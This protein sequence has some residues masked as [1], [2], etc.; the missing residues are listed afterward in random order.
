V[1]VLTL[2]SNVHP[3]SVCGR[4]ERPE[5]THDF[6]QEIKDLCIFVYRFGDNRLKTQAMLCQIYHHALHDRFYE[7]RLWRL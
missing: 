2:C 7:V 1:A 6:S 3:A 5:S 4:P